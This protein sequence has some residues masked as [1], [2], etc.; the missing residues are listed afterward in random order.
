AATE[1]GNAPLLERILLP[2]LNVRGIAGGAVGAAASNTIPPEATA[3]LDLRLVPDQSIE[4][5]HALV[6]DHLR[7]QGYTVVRDAP[8]A[9]TRR[10]HALIALVQWQPG[11]Y[12]A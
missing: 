5:L 7:A 2:A 8:D 11:G 6:E 3:S 12:P 10:A 4:R 1:A 9:A